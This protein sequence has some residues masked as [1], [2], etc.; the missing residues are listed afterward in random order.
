MDGVLMSKSELK[1][2]R[3]A[4]NVIEN[5][6]SI[7]EFSDLIEKSYRQARRIIKKIKCLGELGAI[8]GNTSKAPVNKSDQ[9]LLEQIHKLHKT[10]YHDFNLTHFHEYLKEDEGIGISYS[11]LYRYSKPKGMIK[12]PKRRSKKKFSTRPRLPKEGMLIQFDGS[13]HIW[14]GSFK[15]DLIAA[16]DDATGKIVGAEFFIG[17]TSLHSMKVIRDVVESKGI[18]EAF[19]LDEAA[20]YGK[21]DRDW[22][23]QIKRALEAI[24]SK[25]IIAKTPQAKGRVERLFR[26]L[27]DRLISELKLHQVQ[28]VPAANKFLKEVFIP[29]FNNQFTVQPRVKESAYL[30]ISSAINYELIFCRKIERK[31]TSGNTFSYERTIYSL[32]EAKNYAFRTININTHYDGRV[33]YDIMGKEIAVEIFE[34]KKSK[35]KRLSA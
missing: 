6:L 4:M 15:T 31:I 20:I 26:T 29:K 3:L 24:G 34:S 30:P 23:S 13:E 28:T 14:F 8:H 32:R 5:K 22:D 11:S 18:P 25:L 35:L 33:T 12:N 16:I 17:E 7:T 19:Y 9:D 27:Q 21:I 10:K 2:F 1:T